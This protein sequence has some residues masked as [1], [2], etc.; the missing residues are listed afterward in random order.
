MYYTAVVDE[1]QSFYHLVGQHE[2]RFQ[3]KSAIAR[4]KQVR[5][6]RTHQI[7][8]CNL[9]T[10]FFTKPVMSGDALLEA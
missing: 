4:V 1:L 10:V 2:D 8:Y 9:V 7:K 3:R 5:Q 6:G